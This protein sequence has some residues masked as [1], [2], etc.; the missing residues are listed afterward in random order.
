MLLDHLDVCDRWCRLEEN[1]GDVGSDRVSVEH[2][3]ERRSD[4]C[5]GGG[6]DCAAGESC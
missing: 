1:T 5:N 2:N 4:L 3:L 6:L